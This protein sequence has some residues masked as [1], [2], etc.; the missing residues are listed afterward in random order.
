MRKALH[1][2]RK[3]LLPAGFAL[4]LASIPLLIYWFYQHASTSQG[5]PMFDVQMPDLTTALGF[6]LSIVGLVITIA[7]TVF[8]RRHR[9]MHAIALL[10]SGLCFLVWFLVAILNS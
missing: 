3:Y 8:S 2:L 1:E 5:V 7:A 6:G 10:C 9:S 4:S